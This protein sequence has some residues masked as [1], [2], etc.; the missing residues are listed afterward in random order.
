M[1]DL[2]DHINPEDM[3]ERKYPNE[4][5]PKTD[6]E[7]FDM[8]N[9]AE[10]GCPELLPQLF[11]KDETMIRLKILGVPQSKQS[12][13]FRI[14]KKKSGQQFVSSYQKKSV[15][16]NERNIA[17]DVKFQLPVNYVPYNEAIGVKV[18]FVF[19]PLKS[20][21]KKKM[22]QL[23]SGEKMYKEAKPDL[24]DNLMKGLFDAM[25]GIVFTDDSRV[26]KVESEKIFGFTPRTEVTLYSL[27]N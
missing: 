13:R 5:V 20:W 1:F 12:A 25:N 17:Y 15:K 4:R 14:V 27:N 16:D 19:P 26:C 2:F 22:A 8:L 23:E 21:S 11:K 24:T 10:N 6:Q 7:K 9:Y 18:L 3:I